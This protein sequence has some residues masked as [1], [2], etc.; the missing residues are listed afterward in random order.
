[1]SLRLERP[2]APSR[3][4][5]PVQGDQ[6]HK[7]AVL[8][9]TSLTKGANPRHVQALGGLQQ[10]AAERRDN[11]PA[12]M[13][14]VRSLNLVSRDIL[15]SAVDHGLASM[16]YNVEFARRQYAGFAS[17]VCDP[18]DLVNETDGWTQEGAE[19]EVAT[20][21]KYATKSYAIYVEQLEQLMEH[22]ASL[23]PVP[24]GNELDKEHSMFLEKQAADGKKGDQTE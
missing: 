22:V 18:S 8:L 10:A 6:H 13:D 7:V 15:L 9:E 20:R 23:K 21:K 1:M 14:R 2:V 16:L 5:N 12:I 19:T 11:E 4:R 24:Y 3:R 17:Q